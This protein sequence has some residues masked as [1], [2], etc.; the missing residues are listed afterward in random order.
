MLKPRA[1]LLDEPLSALEPAFR[2]EIKQLL[3]SLHAELAIP[4]VLVSHSFS[5]VLYLA[6][7]GAII[8]QGCLQQSGTI[9]DLFERPISSF[10]ASFVGMKNIFPCQANSNSVSLEKI[11]LQTNGRHNPQATHLAIRPEEIN[12]VTSP[13]NHSGYENILQGRLKRLDCQGF[14]FKVTIEICDREFQA[15]WTRQTV[16]THGLCPGKKV[17]IGFSAK[18]VHTFWD[19]SEC[20][21]DG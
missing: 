4:F 14:Y 21:P 7:K 13:S 15:I 2:D 11:T 5:E 1:L 16:N 20:L 6:N 18:A 9:E 17:T 3:K 19:K 12:L 10:V 8:S